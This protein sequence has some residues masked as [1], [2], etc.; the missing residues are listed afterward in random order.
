MEAFVSREQELYDFMMEAWPGRCGDK[1]TLPRWL[2]KAQLAFPS[3]DLVKEAKK[4][5]MWEAARPSRTK[6][7]VRRFLTNWWANSQERAAGKPASVVP[8]EAARWLKRHNK[9]PDFL[10]KRWVD[11]RGIDNEQIDAFCAYFGVAVPYC[12]EELIELYEEG[13]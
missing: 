4:A 5:F 12:Y 1:S 6:K 11:K 7:S 9:A 10:F 2:G 8:I 13:M 3:V